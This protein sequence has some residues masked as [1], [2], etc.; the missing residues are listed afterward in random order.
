MHSAADHV[1]SSL[2]LV[3]RV[4]VCVCVCVNLS[5]SVRTSVSPRVCMPRDRGRVFTLPA[6][7]PLC[8]GLC[9]S[10]VCDPEVL[11]GGVEH[12]HT[13]TYARAHIYILTH[14]HTASNAIGTQTASLFLEAA[15]TQWAY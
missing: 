15:Q 13:H 11:G 14:T 3:R 10:C 6:A 1:Q 8:R 12:T 7:R 5:Q 9:A 4:C 2:P